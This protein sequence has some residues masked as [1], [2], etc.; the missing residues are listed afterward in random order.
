MIATQKIAANEGTAKAHEC[1][2]SSTDNPKTVR[3]RN[4]LPRASKAPSK[5]RRPFCAKMS[6]KRKREKSKRPPATTSSM[7][8]G[9]Q[10]MSNECTQDGTFLICSSNARI[11]T[12]VIPVSNA[13]M[14]IQ[15]SR[16]RG[17]PGKKMNAPSQ[18]KNTPL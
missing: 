12:R 2:F 8:N 9:L 13:V 7:L 5:M 4:E 18:R 10:K 17:R 14:D 3:A 16:P 1:I 11:V 6:L 15:E